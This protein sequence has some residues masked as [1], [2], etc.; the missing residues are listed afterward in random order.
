MKKITRSIFFTLCAFLFGSALANDDAV[1]RRADTVLTR[2]DILRIIEA[3]VPANA[4][5]ALL[6]DEKKLR[7]FIAQAFA[8][9]MLAAEAMA[10]DLS[11][12]ERWQAD[13]ARE[14]ALAQVQMNHLIAKGLQADY[15]SNAREFYLARPE[16][17]MR[18]E[19]VHVQH[20]LVSTASRSREEAEA[21]VALVLEQIRAGERSFEELARQYS[22]DSSVT[23]NG[24]DLGFFA[25]GRMIAEFEDAAFAMQKPGELAGP[26]ETNFGFH[27]IRF[28]DRR[29]QEQ[30]PFER[31]KDKLEADERA[32]A[33]R[34][35][36]IR[37]YERIGQLPGIEVNQEAINLLRSAAGASGIASSEKAIDSAAK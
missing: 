9:K 6:A 32:K 11:E 4:R 15:S 18:P 2:S 24:G 37:E 12:E 5:T 7:D 10:R 22:D 29:P 14:R 21:R 35:L 27:I 16:E 17:F 36:I 28:V 19:Q 34:A 26:V 31:V 8:G 1:V 3:N 25:R 20:I 13:Y 23:D 33:R 30:I